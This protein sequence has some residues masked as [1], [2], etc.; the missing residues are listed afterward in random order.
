MV[1]IAFWFVISFLHTGDDFL[2]LKVLFHVFFLLVHLLEVALLGLLAALDLLLSWDSIN[3]LG[4]FQQLLLT[5]ETLHGEYL[6]VTSVSWWSHVWVQANHLWLVLL[7]VLLNNWLV[8][9]S[10]GGHVSSL[11]LLLLGSLALGA[12]GNRG[13]LTNLGRLRC[14]WNSILVLSCWLLVF[15]HNYYNF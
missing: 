15:A 11:L 3:V 9:F 13:G 12:L 4:G 5:P 6:G 1:M 7:L 8:L 10:D 14:N 2:E